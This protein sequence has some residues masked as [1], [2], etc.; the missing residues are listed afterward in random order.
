MFVSAA[1]L[2]GCAGP[3]NADTRI[4]QEQRNAELVRDAFGRGVGG[5]DTFYSILAEDVQWTVARAVEPTTYTNR[6]QFLDNGAQPVLRRLTGPIQ[7]EVG[8]VITD[9]DKVVAL[10]K[11]TATAIDGR[12][13]ANEYAWVMTLHDERVTRVVAHLDLVVLNELIARVPLPA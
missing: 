13:Y 11:G 5:P 10:W 4:E 12:P 8:E 7:A 1:V 2:A 6:Q 3:S 9:G